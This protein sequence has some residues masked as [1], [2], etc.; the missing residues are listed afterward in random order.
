MP[1]SGC[2]RPLLGA[3]CAWYARQVLLVAKEG[4]LF[5]HK[6]AQ[7]YK[8]SS[9]LKRRK[10]RLS[11]LPATPTKHRGEQQIGDSFLAL[12]MC[13]TRDDPGS[14]TLKVKRPPVAFLWPHWMQKLSSQRSC[15]GNSPLGRHLRL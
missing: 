5:C 15:R 4:K 10:Q 13:R 8:P 7:Q 11:Q 1:V 2:S 6:V 3:I 9:L 14:M 12:S